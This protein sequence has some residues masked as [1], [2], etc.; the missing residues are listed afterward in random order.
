[1]RAFSETWPKKNLVQQIVA[2]VV[3]RGDFAFWLAVDISF[4]G[5]VSD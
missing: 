3:T 4:S 2:Q 1:M 5:M